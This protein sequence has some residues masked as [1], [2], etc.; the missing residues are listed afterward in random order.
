MNGK[1]LTALV[2]FIGALALI[3]SQTQGSKT[4]EFEAWKVKY[5]ISYSSQFENAY[6]EKIFLR[7]LAEIEAHNSK[8]D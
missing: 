2:V 7:N 8:E 4:S 6:R 3:L 1:Q 5:G